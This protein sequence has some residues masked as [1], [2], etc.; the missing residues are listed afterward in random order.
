VIKVPMR[1]RCGNAFENPG[2]YSPDL[3][4]VSGEG[5]RL[6]AESAIPSIEAVLQR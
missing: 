5:H 6:W 2:I 3:L 1:E 4:H